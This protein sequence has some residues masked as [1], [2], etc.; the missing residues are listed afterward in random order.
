MPDSH[1]RLGGAG[2]LLKPYEENTQR[3][4]A[5]GVESLVMWKSA[6]EGTDKGQLQRN[7]SR[8]PR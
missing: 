2:V 1:H 6:W 8:K 4:E 7:G 5:G 3:R